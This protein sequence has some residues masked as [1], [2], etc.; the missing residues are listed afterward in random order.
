VR[1]YST[2]YRPTAEDLARYKFSGVTLA[3]LAGLADQLTSLEQQLATLLQVPQDTQ[4]AFFALASLVDQ[5]TGLEQQLA[6]LL[7]VPQDTQMVALQ[8]CTG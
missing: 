4:V 1:I 8:C 7:H 2:T 5:L 6:T 3:G